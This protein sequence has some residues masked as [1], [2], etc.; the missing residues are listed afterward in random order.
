MNL[1]FGQ[2]HH[3][4][5]APDKYGEIGKLIDKKLTERKI[6]KNQFAKE[7]GISASYLAHIMR[8]HYDDSP[9]VPI[10]FK[11]LGIKKSA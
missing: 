6:S 1:N 4:Q 10:I 7:I 3:F 11:A 2:G 8:G 5:S 9:K